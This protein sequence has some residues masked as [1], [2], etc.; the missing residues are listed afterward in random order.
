[1]SSDNFDINKATQ[2]IS[3]IRGFGQEATGLVGDFDRATG[4]QPLRALITILLVA[5]GVL[6]VM[7]AL[8]MEP[9]RERSLVLAMG[10][11]MFL[12]SIIYYVLARIINK[13]LIVGVFIGLIVAIIV[14]LKNAQIL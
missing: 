6:G 3:D 13:I 12:I 7:Y 9:G 11:G 5:G 4:S 14:L 8:S 1:M 10:L 2:G